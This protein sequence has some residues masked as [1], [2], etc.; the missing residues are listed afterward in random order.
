MGSYNKSIAKTSVDAG[1]RSPLPFISETPVKFSGKPAEA[2]PEYKKVIRLNPL[3]PTYYLFGLGHAYCL[4]GQY[5]EAIAWCKKQPWSPLIPIYRYL[6]LT[7]VY[8][9]AG[10]D[11][12]ASASAAEV[13]R[14][15]PK[16]SVTKQE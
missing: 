9:M 12:E 15:N 3:P 6:T 14:T 1:S 8:S 5:G 16:Y 11:K 10:Q 2:I 13:L 7:I 4:T